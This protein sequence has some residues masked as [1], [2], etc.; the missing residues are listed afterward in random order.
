LP[1]SNEELFDMVRD[2][3]ADLNAFTKL[4]DESNP[5]LAGEYH[6]RADQLREEFRVAWPAS[7]TSNAELFEML[8]DLQAD[9]SALTKLMFEASPELA[10]EY[11]RRA[12][13]LREEF[14]QTNS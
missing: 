13:E 1:P 7:E 2:L 10:G 14:R 12:D 3:Q 8:R 5:E 6:R 11:R 4:M 9:V